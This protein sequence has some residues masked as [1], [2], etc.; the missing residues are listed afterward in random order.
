M[1]YLNRFIALV[2][3][4]SITS[5]SITGESLEDDIA[6]NYVGD[7][8]YNDHSLGKDATTVSIEKLSDGEIVIYGFHNLGR[9]VSTNF[10]VEGHELTITSSKVDGL[11]ISGS[12]TSNYNYDEITIQ[13][14]VDGDDYEANL[15]KLG[16]M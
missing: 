7:W 15:I 5:C 10:D 3:F 6:S 14:N 9:S 1:N 8:S 16:E 2:M 11:P 12:G 4:I 13:Y